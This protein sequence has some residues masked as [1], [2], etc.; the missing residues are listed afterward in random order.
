MTA[1]INASQLLISLAENC[2]EQRMQF[3]RMLEWTDLTEIQQEGEYLF[4]KVY[5]NIDLAL[6]EN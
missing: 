2:G 3:R 5:R 6:K 1:N 4:E